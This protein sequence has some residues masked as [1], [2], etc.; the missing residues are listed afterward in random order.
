MSQGGVDEV[1]P[2]ML[3]VGEL[4][5]ALKMAPSDSIPESFI[6]CEISLLECRLD[7]A[8]H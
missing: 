8:T 2:G 6:V 5:A 1:I 3:L 7:L 4:Q